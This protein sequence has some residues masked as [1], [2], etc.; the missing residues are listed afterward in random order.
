[1]K[2]QEHLTSESESFLAEVEKSLSSMNFS[3]RDEILNE[4]RTHISQLISE[5]ESETIREILGDPKLYALELMKASGFE[6]SKKES[7]F[8]RLA[9][10]S[11]AAKA[12]IVAF[13]IVLFGWG[14]L[15]LGILAHNFQIT[16]QEH[17]FE[18]MQMVPDSYYVVPDFRGLPASY[19]VEFL[20][21]ANVPLCSST[22]L[23]E[24]SLENLEVVSQLPLP[25]EVIN[26]VIQCVEL[27]VVPR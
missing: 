25:G 17:S 7:R 6:I 10:L 26:S 15:A 18:N 14:V 11:T 8:P 21:T 19:S 20:T 27:T 2:I 12:L 24:G 9:N 13:G 22:N 4:L 1:M 16:S 3:D 5:G 23:R